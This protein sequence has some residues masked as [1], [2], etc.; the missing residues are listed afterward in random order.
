MDVIFVDNMAENADEIEELQ[1]RLESQICGSS[2]EVLSKFAE[3][4]EVNVEGLRKIQ[5]SKRVREKIE[6]KVEASEDKKALLEGYFEAL[7]PP[8]SPPP[9]EVVEETEID[10][11]SKTNNEYQEKKA[12]PEPALKDP[13][14]KINVDLARALKRDFKIFGVVGGD[15]QKDCL[16]FV[17]LSRL[18]DAGVKSGYQESEIVEAVIRAVSPSL[19]LR[20]Y[21]E[22]MD[23]L[24]LVRLK[25]ILRA[26]FKEKT[27]TELYQELTSLCQGPKE[28]AQ[29]FLMRAMNLREQ[30]LF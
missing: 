22:M 30:V 8:R 4:V 23:N 19:K 25:Q 29:D 15:R 20:P 2:V 16:S 3:H 28:S 9:L 17:S 12:D 7:S 13:T 24:S 5:I 26:H 18:I 11:S 27:G 14:S 10:T 6:S 1:L 21:L